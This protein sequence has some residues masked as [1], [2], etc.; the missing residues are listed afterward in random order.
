MNV[1]GNWRSSSN[2]YYS[3]QVG[4]NNCFNLNGGLNFQYSNSTDYVTL[5]TEP[6]RSSVRSMGITPS[7]GVSY[8]LPGDR[9]TIGVNGSVYFNNARSE[10]KNFIPIDSRDYNVGVRGDIH[11]P[12]DMQLASSLSLR[13]RRNYSDNSMN[14]IE[15][16]W[17]ASI[18]KSVLK[19][20]LTIRLEAVDILDSVKDITVY[21]NSQ[22]RYETWQNSLPRYVMLSLNYRF[23]MKP[24]NKR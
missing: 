17:N 21:V 19:K 11:L 16:L 3:I 5:E 14:T 10:R 22:G 20:K 2:L 7:A 13:M 1:N 9:G 12:W 15:W 18:E 4:R 6:E 24:R 23:D 8:Q